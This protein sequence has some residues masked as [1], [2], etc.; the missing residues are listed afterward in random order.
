MSELSFCTIY[1]VPLFRGGDPG[2]LDTG[3]SWRDG[4]HGRIALL[5]EAQRDIDNELSR[6]G[7][8]TP[9]D[10]RDRAAMMRLKRDKAAELASIAQADYAALEVR[11]TAGY[12]VTAGQWRRAEE[13]MGRT[14]AAADVWA[15][16]CR[17]MGVEE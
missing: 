12:T 8:G 10:F 14:R 17:V 9:P 5:R 11:G 7:E 6:Y 16:A 15:E 2:D 1:T 13:A 3:P 4:E